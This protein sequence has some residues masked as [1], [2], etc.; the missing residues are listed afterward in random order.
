MFIHASFFDRDEDKP[1]NYYRSCQFQ[2]IIKQQAQ[3]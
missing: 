1:V 3:I 2:M